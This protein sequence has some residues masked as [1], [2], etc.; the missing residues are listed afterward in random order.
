M[1]SVKL[2]TLTS[3]TP[4]FFSS[5]Y[6][7]GKIKS[8]RR[9]SCCHYAK[10]ENVWTSYERNS[11]FW[12]C[13]QDS[14]YNPQRFCSHC[15]FTITNSDL[16]HVDWETIHSLIVV[17]CTWQKYRGVK[18]TIWQWLLKTINLCSL[19]NDFVYCRIHVNFFRANCFIAVFQNAHKNADVN[20]THFCVFLLGNI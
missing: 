19:N 17:H 2:G 6:K 5:P 10:E 13:W 1:D 14:E 20:I 7:N 9:Y 3:R 11:C 4:F 8:K 16:T 15:L 18:I 12:F